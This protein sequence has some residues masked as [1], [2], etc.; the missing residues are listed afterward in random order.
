LDR[1]DLEDADLEDADLRHASLSGAD[2]HD[3][4]L[5]G[6]DLTGANLSDAN[7]TSAN[8]P[9]ANLTGARLIFAHPMDAN[10]T[11]TK[12]PQANLYR[13]NLIRADLE[14]T[15]LTD[16]TAAYTQFDNVDLS[17]VRGLDSVQHNGPS[18]IGI[19]TIYRSNGKIPESFPRG[20]G[21]PE[22][23]ITYMRS[24]TGN[25]F[26][27]YSCFISYSTMDQQ[28]SQRLYESLQARG[29]SMLVRAT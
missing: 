12:L 1:A 28:F 10:R 16:A 9:E 17:E 15:D 27:F 8:L 14:G 13:A 29:V 19:D 24:L 23:F 11:D 5:Y 7:L 6:A 26:D 22:T 3:A 20:C 25:A 18:T 21:V 4:N 2:L